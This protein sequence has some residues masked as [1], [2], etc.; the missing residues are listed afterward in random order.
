MANRKED[1]SFDNGVS[2]VVVILVIALV[3]PSVQDQGGE[4]DQRWNGILW[5]N[6]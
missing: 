4:D 1:V 2:V 3:S 5:K 6:A